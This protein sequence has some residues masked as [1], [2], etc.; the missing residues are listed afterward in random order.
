MHP[1]LAC[2]GALALHVL[3]LSLAWR[4]RPAPHFA[5][6]RIQD[7]IEIGLLEEPTPS[8]VTS[9][10]APIR[11]MPNASPRRSSAI[12]GSLAHQSEAPIADGMQ[13]QAIL[14]SG[15]GEDPPVAPSASKTRVELGLDGS[16]VG[17]LV[18]E[19]RKKRTARPTTG[20]DL[21][22]ELDARD[23]AKGVGRSSAALSA[24]YRASDL[25]PPLGSAT[26]DVRADAT[27]R[28][29]S[30][31]LV[32]FGSDAADWRRVGEAL[33]REL[34]KKR[35]RVPRGARGLSSVLRIER[36]E[37]ALDNHDRGRTKRGAAVGQQSMGSKE[38][39]DESTRAAFENGGVAPALGV[40]PSSVGTS[41]NTRVVLVRE[42]PL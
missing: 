24:A 7:D 17:R 20:L 29:T 41:P 9:V 31:V 18:L 6:S 8:P 38:V 42:R 11:P 12:V 3:A 40:G 32:E 33:K 10:A 28:V 4:M 37:M 26:F 14:D 1:A 16:M 35:L 36:G 21:G 15:V 5:G 30:V 27:G 19:E 13:P 22:R 23:A 34:Q 39:K 25:A 2:A